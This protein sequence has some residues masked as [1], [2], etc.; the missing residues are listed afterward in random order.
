MIVSRKNRWVKDIRRLRR[1]KG[2]RAL[3]EGPHLLREALAAGLDLEIVLT[4]PEFAAAPDSESLL[5]PLSDVVQLARSDVLSAAADS[6]SPRGVVAI[7]SLPRRGVSTLPRSAG[8][9]YLY[10]D[11]LQEPGNLGALAR[12]AEAAGVTAVSLGSGCVHPNHPRALRASAGSL[13]RLPVARDVTLGELDDRL[14][15][16]DAVWLALVPGQGEDLF[17]AELPN[18][19]TVL[20][21]GAEGGGLRG[22]SLS[23]ADRCLTLP[24]RPPVESLNV[25]VAAGVALYELRRRRV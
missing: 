10:C 14:D 20:L 12:V 22:A 24:M 25:T 13:L 11:G 16:L 7:A 17:E 15:G 1:S 23:R 4:T 8:G 21:V 5:E 3:L 9:I 2:D 6:D 18:G 19:A